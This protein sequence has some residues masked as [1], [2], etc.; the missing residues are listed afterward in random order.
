MIALSSFLDSIVVSL[1]LTAV[2][3]FLTIPTKNPKRKEHKND[4]IER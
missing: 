3:V 2:L 1:L 4:Y